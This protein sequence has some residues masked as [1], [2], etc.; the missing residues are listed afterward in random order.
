MLHY[1][2]NRSSSQLSPH[3]LKHSG[4]GTVVPSASSMPLNLSTRSSPLTPPSD[5]QPLDL[6]VRTSQPPSAHAQNGATPTTAQVED[7]VLNLSTKVKAA[8]PKL[9]QISPNSILSSTSSSS[10]TSPRNKSHLPHPSSIPPP[11]LRIPDPTGKAHFV[12]EMERLA[13]TAAGVAAS[14]TSASSINHIIGNSITSAAAA[15]AAD[16]ARFQHSDLFKY[17]AQNG[18]FKNGFLPGLTDP[19]SAHR[20]LPPS[21]LNPTVLAQITGVIPPNNHHPQRDSPVKTSQSSPKPQGCV[22]PSK[23]P[24][25]PLK[26]GEW[27]TPYFR[28]VFDLLV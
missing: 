14:T 2:H 16:P 7:Q 28:K 24:G 12:T 27:R 25:S 10:S 18:L 26:T 21:L 1:H 17:M 8:A 15:A 23:E 6:T 13:A 22:T 4:S 19:S 9:E 5:D 11:F 20:K 3:S